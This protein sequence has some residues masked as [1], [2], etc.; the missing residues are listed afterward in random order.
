MTSVKRIR[1]LSAAEAAATTLPWVF[2][3]T[4]DPAVAEAIIKL[5]DHPDAA[6]RG[7]ALS[8]ILLLGPAYRA[9]AWEIL[10]RSVTDESPNVAQRAGKVFDLLIE[11][12][13]PRAWRGRFAV[14]DRFTHEIV[15]D[16]TVGEIHRLIEWALAGNDDAAARLDAVL[17]NPWANQELSKLF[18]FALRSRLGPPT[19]NATAIVSHLVMLIDRLSEQLQSPPAA[20]GNDAKAD[21]ESEKARTI[22]SGVILA[23]IA[24]RIEVHSGLA[25]NTACFDDPTARLFH[26]RALLPVLEA[27]ARSPL[28]HAAYSVVNTIA[29]V[30][31]LD[32]AGV[33][34]LGIRA[35]L[36]GVRS[37]LAFDQFAQTAVRNF[38]MTYLN[39][40]RELLEADRTALNGFMDVLDAFAAVGW[41]AWI[42][43]TFALDAIYR[44]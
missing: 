19:L 32:P 28:P 3:R 38:L 27:L 31:D 8:D 7:A 24:N 43:V 34:Q 37:G 26:Y 1:T 23:E 29:D 2:Q 9:R 39:E 21:P 35:T 33:L 25:R 13:A 44:E 15:N 42:D 14:Y 30:A 18:A 16:F 12:D 10:E 17:N 6:I 11:D 20:T 36:T 4:Q 41:P 5:I 22:T 40:H